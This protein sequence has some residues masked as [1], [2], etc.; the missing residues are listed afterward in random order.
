[1]LL[2][3]FISLVLISITVSKCSSNDRCRP[4]YERKAK[5]L[6]VEHSSIIT[7]CASNEYRKCCSRINAVTK[8]K[9]D[10]GGSN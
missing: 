5:E 7:G 9:K 8:E 4:L 1:M 3:F 6:K 10:A 2:L